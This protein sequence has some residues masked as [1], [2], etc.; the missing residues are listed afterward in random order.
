MENNTLEQIRALKQAGKRTPRV[1]VIG[2][3]MSGICM[4]IRLLEAGIEDF[5]IYE[6]KEKIGGTWREN[7]YP[8]LACDVPSYFYTYSFEQNPNW[9]HRFP[10][11][12]EIQEY[13]ESVFEKYGL[14]AYTRFN[15]EIADCR[16]EEG[17]WQVDLAD[18]ETDSGEFLIAATGVLHQVSMPTIKG[19]KSFA[20]DQFHSARW[21][22]D[23]ELKGKRIGIIG[24]GSTAL[25]MVAPLSEVAGKL[26]LFQRTAQWVMSAPNKEY[27]ESWKKR[28]ANSPRLAKAL[29][30]GYKM[31]IEQTLG[32]AVIKPGWRRSVVNYMCEKNLKTVK[33]RELRHKLTPTYEPGCKRIVVS[34]T[35]YPAIQKP[36]CAVVTDSI[37]CIEPAGVRTKDGQLHELDVLV[38]CTGFDGLA[39][40]RPMAMTGRDGLTLAQAWESGPKALRSLT[41]P[42]FPNFF[43]LIGPHSPIGNYS[44]IPLAEGQSMYAMQCIKM[45]M[46]GTFDE[47]EPKQEAVT[48]FYQQVNTALADTVWASGCQSWYLGDDGV[49]ALWPWSPQRFMGEIAKPN[50]GDYVLTRA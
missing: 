24:S 41:I 30:R 28:V 17:R 23:V 36:N 49:P 19:L 4:G 13:F 14:A 40:M 1:I 38:F 35:F 43:M 20:G 11:G 18:G 16:F 8:G 10:P 6:K 48:E 12:A 29:Y 3:G 47:L 9:T 32:K 15:T 7:T 25:Q 27:S 46:E 33:D 26:E 34:E 37:E 39:F 31:M 5:V 45:Y 21:D 42:G 50:I 44:L 22:H 2:A